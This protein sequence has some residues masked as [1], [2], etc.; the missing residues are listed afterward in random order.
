MNPNFNITMNFGHSELRGFYK[1]KDGKLT[2]YGYR[3]DY[4]QH[5]NETGRTEP[6]AYSSIGFG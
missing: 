4:D 2:Y 1:P 3:I 5:G 6:T